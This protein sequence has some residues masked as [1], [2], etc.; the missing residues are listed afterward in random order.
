MAY[1]RKLS[2]G[3]FRVEIKHANKFIQTKP[4]FRKMP[5]SHGQLTLKRM[6]RKFLP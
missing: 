5:Q 4:F 3:K 2:N 6:L 1:V